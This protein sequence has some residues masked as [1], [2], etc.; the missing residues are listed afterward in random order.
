MPRQR[1][2][3]PEKDTSERWLLTYSDLITLLMIFFVVMYA[4]SSVNAT[5][6]VALQESLA[7]ALHQSDRIPVNLGSSSLVMSANPSDNGQKQDTLT[8][9]K[10][11]LPQDA[12]L[13]RLYQEINQFI[14]Q[15]DL[16]NYVQITNQV[17]GVQITMRDIVLF[18]TG[19]A[20]IR[21]HAQT[22]LNGLL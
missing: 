22:I 17:R 1:R 9:T 11:T 2:P 8:S 16:V 10:V 21:P 13:D 18:D 20:V 5:K 3:K 15:H 4:M 19:K 7:A 6:F 12:Q 14:Q